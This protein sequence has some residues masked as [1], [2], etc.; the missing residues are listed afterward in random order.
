MAVLPGF[1]WRPSI[2]RTA[3]VNG[4]GLPVRGAWSSGSL[5]WPAKDPADILDYVLD[6][7]GALLGDG[8]DSIASLNVQSAP[9]GVGDLQV[10]SAAADGER[11]ILWLASGQPGTTYTIS[12]VISTTAGRVLARSVTLLVLAIAAPIA[13]SGALTDS[14]GAILTDG[15]GQPLLV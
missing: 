4:S 9:N 7:S 6:A 14:T 3:F 5:S 12:I 10:Q 15:N 8:G 2:A 11:A 13:A 1:V